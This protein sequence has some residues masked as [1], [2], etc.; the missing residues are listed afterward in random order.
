MQAFTKFIPVVAVLLIGGSSAICQSWRLLLPFTSYNVQI[1]RLDS[2]KLY[3]GYRSNQIFR[4][5]DGGLSWELVPIGTVGVDN[6]IT[7]LVVSSQ[8]TGT[9]FVG[10]FLFNGIK[11]SLDGGG[12]WEYVERDPNPVRQWF[13]S[14]AI[15]E[16]PRSPT[17]MYA[18]RG[19]SYNSIY[20]SVDAGSSWDSISTIPPSF[21]TRLCTITARPD[22]SG[23]LFAGCL[24][25]V[26]TRSDDAGISWRRVPVLGDRFSIS[27]D[28]EIAKI[29]FSRN[30]PMQGY[31]V[32][33]IASE[34]NVSGGGGLLKTVDGGESWNR[35]AFP[36]TSFWAVEVLKTP[37]GI[38]EVLVGGFKLSVL[39]NVIKGDS[40]VYKST[41]AGVTWT[42]FEGIRWDSTADGDT[43]RNVWMLRRDT[44]GKKTYMATEMG[45]Y[46][47]DENPSSVA[48]EVSPSLSTFVNGNQL[49]VVDS[50]P[51]ITDKTWA[52]YSMNAERLESGAIIDPQ[53]QT[54]DIGSLNTGVYLLVWGSETRF[55]TSMIHI[56]R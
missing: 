12:T 34:E 14:D 39:Q 28:A 17:I 40:L 5:N 41:D 35:I 13:I 9:I 18:A 45:L 33:T 22:S 29:V 2:Q 52:I 42:R 27:S 37:S 8:D 24:G 15:I 10:G 43:A 30:N 25:G 55:R 56:L 20:K 32:V 11:R 26:I 38:D 48:E 19:S 51:I 50:D 49:V 1:N 54:I 16:D 6:A 7:S 31:A 23:I 44:V 53:Q 21:T 3:V 36:D 47:L 46:V 4:S